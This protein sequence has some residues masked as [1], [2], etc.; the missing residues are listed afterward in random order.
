M[1]K[2]NL[3]DFTDN[4]LSIDYILVTEEVIGVNWIK[5]YVSIN[6]SDIRVLRFVIYS[7]KKF[8][9]KTGYLRTRNNSSLGL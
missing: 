8:S 3:T 1:F 6:K 7:K 4:S 5:L 2:D 9:V